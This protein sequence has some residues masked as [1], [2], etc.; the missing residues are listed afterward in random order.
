VGVTPRKVEQF[1]KAQEHL[2]M[3]FETTSGQL[4][5]IAFFAE[6]QDFEKNPEVHT[7]FTLIAH[8]EQSYFMGRQQIR[9]R[10]IDII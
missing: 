7:I 6:S 9:L 8:V 10:I 5:A 1:G 4:E 3:I 2:K